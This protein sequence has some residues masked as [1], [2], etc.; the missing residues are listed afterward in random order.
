MKT[1]DKI[2]IFS[3]LAAMI[4]ASYAFGIEP[5]TWEGLLLL[6]PALVVGSAVDWVLD[7]REEL[8]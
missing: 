4:A 6:I 7:R 1:H 3:G 2:A 5:K 8:G